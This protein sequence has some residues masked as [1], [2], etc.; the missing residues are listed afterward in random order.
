MVRAAPH[1]R[2]VAVLSGLIRPRRAGS[3]LGESSVSRQQLC[4]EGGEDVRATAI[5][6]ATYHDI[7]RDLQAGSRDRLCDFD[8]GEIELTHRCYLFFISLGCGPADREY[9][10]TLGFALHLH[11]TS[12]TLSLE[13]GLLLRL[14]RHLHANLR[15]NEIDL[16][17]GLGAASSGDS[18]GSPNT[19]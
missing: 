10:L 13:Y 14:L 17:I 7:R 8:S 1:V 9:L 11:R 18:A 5:A 19:R 4:D 3:G 12:T 15:S 6:A 16:L 2:L